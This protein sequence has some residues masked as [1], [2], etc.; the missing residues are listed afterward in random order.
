MAGPDASS[1][2]S[3]IMVRLFET[4]YDYLSGKRWL[5]TAF[6]LVFLM[7]CVLLSTR[8]HYEE[9]ISKF[10]PRDEQ[11]ARYTEVYQ[12]LTKQ[13]KIVVV[14]ASKDTL[15]V[16]PSDSIEQAMNFFEETLQEVDSTGVI[17]D[18]Q[19][20]VD[21]SQMMEVM[22]FIG[23]NAPYFLQEDD[24]QRMDSLLQQSDYIAEQM[25]ENKKLLNLPTAGSRME[26]LR[27]DPLH[28]F[29]T[30]L[31]RM[32]D[33]RMTSSFEV[34]N[35]TVFTHDGRS[36][37]AFLS[38][39]Y[40]MSESAQN[41]AL[42]V[43]LDSVMQQTEHSYPSLQVSAIGAPLVAAG[44]ARQIKKDSMLAVSLA[45]V[46]ILLLLI[47]HYRRLSYLW[48]LGCALIFGWLF[49]LAGMTLFRDSVSII[50][51]GIGSVIIGIAVNYPLHFLDHLREVGDTR[52]TLRDMVPPLLIGNITTVSAFLCL[53]W[54][55]A[56]AMRDLGLFGSL[57]LIGTILF[58]LVFLP[59][60]VGRGKTG[61]PSVSNAQ[62][63]VQTA[64]YCST[65]RSVRKYT[66]LSTTVRNLCILLI[67]IVL[68]YFS[69]KTSFDSDLRNINYMT[70]QQQ[71]D[72]Q[73]L[74]AASNEAPVY[75]VAEGKTLDEALRE[76]ETAV[77]PKMRVLEQ[78]GGIGKVSGVGQFLPTQEVQTERLHRWEQFWESHTATVTA[79][80][81]RQ[82]AAQGF[83][84]QAFDPF[85]EMLSTHFEPQSLTFFE[86]IVIL[87]E[88]TYILN[89]KEMGTVRV[90]NYVQTTDEEMVKKVVNNSTP[91]SYA[92]SAQDVGNQLVKVL[93]DSFNYIGFVCGFVV[94]FFLWL[95]FGSI[96]LSLMSFLPLAVSWVW[97]LGLMHL[98]GIQFN[99][100]NV[101]L[102]TFI[103]GQGDDYTI[104]ITEG[105]L[106]EY[107]TGKKRLASYKRSVALSAILMF[108]G[109]GTLIF[110]KHPALRSLAAVTIIGMFT[111]VLMAYYLPPLVFRWLTRGVRTAD[112]SSLTS[113]VSSPLPITLGRFLRSLFSIVFFL[114][115][116]YLFM[117]PF[118]WLYFHIGKN[119]EE[120]KLRY[121]RLLQ[122]V[123]DF[124]I[125]RVPGVKFHLENRVGETFEKPAVIICNHQSHL[126]LM[127]LM[128]LTPRMVFL[129]N[130][131]VWH[132]PFYGMVIHRAEFYPVSDGIENHID[133]LK[134]LYNRG[135]SIAVFPEGTRSVD[136]SIQRFHK[137][138]F[139]LAE[140]LQT[141]ILPII[142]HGA[143]H[144]LP[145]K[146]FM[147][148]QG[149]ID[150]EVHE[151]IK[152]DDQRF[153]SDLLTRTKQMRAYYKEH[154]AAMCEQI[155]TADY[156]RPYQKYIEKYQMQT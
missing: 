87:L 44:N 84:A 96:E 130:D 129:T 102:A 140:Q 121:H 85:F 95:S 103:F 143:G 147:L 111:V 50:V 132:N 55:D 64:P 48:W 97:I 25:T 125:H 38:S 24:Y 81:K 145:K 136:C 18:L 35:G 69:T 42:Q 72:M 135:Y 2:N 51:L 67:T 126:D 93:S 82:C 141:D 112:P 76:N 149:R 75:A 144:V 77:M 17:K 66:K 116:M 34:V 106:Y 115:M 13:D 90:V 12:S 7:V 89:D 56:A 52:Q 94:F 53:V 20:H 113:H 128:M 142:L 79:E 139:Y 104:F 134:S 78:E 63:A 151:R 119:T 86:P 146:D 33:F 107:T 123:S 137:G 124:V 118:T 8:I 27:Y 14:F 43:M 49:A 109:I 40:G 22:D 16:T 110:A 100:V 46:L 99:I 39:P 120:K 29:T 61:R 30:V 98:L 62:N 154:Y 1:I 122:K 127:C 6:L 47:V 101:I 3:C 4:I 15:N 117:L 156:W 54:L 152:L 88:D 133:Q 45:V 32:Q 114:L 73:L 71:K 70:A 105:L 57:M 150:V 41:A 11:N 153:S 19:V 68:G 31:G 10:L 59:V 65:D 80:L 155:E 91:S 9:D 74:A 37:L 36:A 148:R 138:A 23:E 58:V 5:V 60:C 83:N 108:I 26:S 21:E 131:W 28:L 92:F